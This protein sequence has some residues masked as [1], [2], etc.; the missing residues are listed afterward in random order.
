M[1]LTNSS[2]GIPVAIENF[3]SSQNKTKKLYVNNILT[4]EIILIK[5]SRHK[6][7]A[8]NTCSESEKES[9]N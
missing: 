3:N 8:R 1:D 2:R 9:Y 5:I 6:L 4:V 7:F